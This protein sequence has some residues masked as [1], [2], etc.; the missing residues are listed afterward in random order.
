MGILCSR[1]CI[2]VMSVH[3]IQQVPPVDRRM[4]ENLIL[5]SSVKVRKDYQTGIQS[6][7]FDGDVAMTTCESF[8]APL[9]NLKSLDVVLLLYA[10]GA[11]SSQ[12]IALRN[13]PIHSKDVFPNLVN[14]GLAALYDVPR[15]KVWWW[16]R[17][18][19][20]RGYYPLN[21]EIAKAVRKYTGDWTAWQMMNGKPR[22]VDLDRF[23]K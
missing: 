22:V 3:V 15:L 7:W 5:R 19:I 2:E 4:I 1:F 20:H 6:R 17:S 16:L 10:R 23:I 13:L 14:D 12:G 18:P 9:S 8:R 11:W 21:L